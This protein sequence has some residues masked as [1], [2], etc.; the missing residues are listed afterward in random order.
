MCNDF[1]FI[2]SSLFFLKVDNG[3]SAF[4]DSSN[5]MDNVRFDAD[6]NSASPFDPPPQEDVPALFDSSLAG[7]NSF[8]LKSFDCDY[9]VIIQI[10]VKGA[11]IKTA[12]FWM[13]QLKRTGQKQLVAIPMYVF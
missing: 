3:A 8:C 6:D 10:K 9:Q 2:E 1:D 13:L 12:S 7:T 5:W 11:R 4:G